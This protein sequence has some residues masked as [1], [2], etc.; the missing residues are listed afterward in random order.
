MGVHRKSAQYHRVGYIGCIPHMPTMQAQYK[1][2]TEPWDNLMM[3]K[4]NGFDRV[5]ELE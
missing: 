4:P 3:A 2:C 5:E 1:N